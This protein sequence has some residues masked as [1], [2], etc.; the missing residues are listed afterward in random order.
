MSDL[1][2][3]TY[4]LYDNKELLTLYTLHIPDFIPFIA[5]HLLNKALVFC[6]VFILKWKGLLWEHIKS[7]R[8]FYE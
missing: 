5:T 8:P 3:Y 6:F 4:P 7:L 2:G 1:I